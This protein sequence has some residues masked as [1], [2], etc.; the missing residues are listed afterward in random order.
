MTS[1]IGRHFREG[2]LNVIR[3]GWMSFA[4]I[5]AVIVTLAVLGLSLIITMNAAQMSK[6]VTNQLEFSAFLSVSAS[7][8]AQVQLT[9]QVQSLSDVKSVQLISQSQG[10][11]QMEQKLGTQYKDILSGLKSNPIPPQLVVTPKDPR[12]ILQ[13]SNEVAKLPGI[14][15]VRDPH[16]IVGAIFSTLDIVRDIGV[17][18]V[19]ALFITSMFLISNTIRIT[20]FSRRREIEIMKLVGATNWFIRWPFIVEG[21]IIGFLGALVPLAILG[22]GYDELYARAN[23]MFRGIAFPLVQAGDLAT[24]LTVVLIGIGLFIG[25]WGGTMS[26]RKFLRV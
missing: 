4:A 1:R 13:V 15:T 16:Q 23:G 6:Y 21:M 26:V 19:I 7:K 2:F 5:S 18:F 11:A 8:Q 25:I 3:N 12:N 22:F 24:K 10:L 17:I 20:I 9:N 14:A